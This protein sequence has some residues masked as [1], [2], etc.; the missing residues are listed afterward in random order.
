MFFRV[1][2]SYVLDIFSG[3][4]ETLFR[5]ESCCTAFAREEQYGFHIEC[6]AEFRITEFRR[7]FAE[8]FPGIKLRNSVFFTEFRI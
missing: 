2:P 5:G 8:F 7:N 1:V 4:M 6:P 3:K